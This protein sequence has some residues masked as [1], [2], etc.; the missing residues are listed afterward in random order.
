MRFSPLLDN[1]TIRAVIHRSQIKINNVIIYFN[2][3]CG[4]CH[5]FT[6]LWELKIIPKN[7]H[8]VAITSANGIFCLDQF[9]SCRY[10]SL[11]YIF[12]K[13]YWKRITEEKQPKYSISNRISQFCCQNYPSALENL[14]IAE[15]VII[16]KAHPIVTILKLKPNYRFNPGSYRRIR[17]HAIILSQNTRA[18]LILFPSDLAVIEDIVR[19]IWLKSNLP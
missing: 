15:E 14:S 8:V 19:I 4:N 11:L 10:L 16:A 13:E 12:C 7:S 17:S 18:L 5:W 6:H 1:K 9:D 3:V 2:C